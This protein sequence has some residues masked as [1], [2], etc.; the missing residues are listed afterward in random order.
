MK[1]PLMTP[2]LSSSLDLATLDAARKVTATALKAYVCEL[3][4]KAL[5]A[6]RCRDYNAAKLHSDWAFAAD[7]CV[8]KVSVALNALVVEAL[9]AMPLVQDTRTVKLPDLGRSDHDRHLEALTV[10]VAPEQTEPVA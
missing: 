1:S 6:A 9:E 5:D 3:E 7:L 2:P 10:E 8:L 4:Q